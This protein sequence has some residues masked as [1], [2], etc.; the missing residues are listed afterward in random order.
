M[1]DAGA[2]T[3]DDP[4]IGDHPLIEHRPRFVIVT[5]PPASG[6]STVAPALARGLGLPLIAKDVIKD[7]LLSVLPVPDVAASRQVGRASVVAMFAVAG[8]SPIGAVIESN[9]RRSLAGDEIAD[10]GGTVVEVFCRCDRSVALDRYRR[11]SGSRSAGHFDTERTDGE[12]WNPDVAEPV[13][14]GWPVLEVDTNHPV[15]L[16]DLVRRVDAAAAPT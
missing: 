10:L 16:A 15:D 3:G 11:R 4:L 8:A 13:A 6:K 5:G 2:L 12:I 14:G 7:A 9:L 1:S